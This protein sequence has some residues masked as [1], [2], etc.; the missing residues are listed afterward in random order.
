M[1]SPTQPSKIALPP[2][3]GFAAATNPTRPKVRAV[4]DDSP[5]PPVR[6]RVI[7]PSPESLGI[8]FATPSS[9]ASAA[10]VD[11]NLVHARLEHLGVVN[12]QRNRLPQGGFRV[13]VSLPTTQLPH[14]VEASGDTEAAAVLLA[15]H[16]AESW[17]ASQR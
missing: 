16:R 7:L 5:P 9:V 3:P 14:D 1:Q 13:V 8:K 11:W 15:L 12:F 4:S 2:P 10:A 17:V 6:A